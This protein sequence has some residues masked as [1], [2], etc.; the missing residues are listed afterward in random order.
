MRSAAGPIKV[1]RWDAPMSIGA[2][3]TAM[4]RGVRDSLASVMTSPQPVT[5]RVAGGARR[6]ISMTEQNS[7]PRIFC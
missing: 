5:I 3:I 2:P 7:R 4:R 1:P 6:D